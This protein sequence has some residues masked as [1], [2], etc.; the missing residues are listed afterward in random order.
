MQQKSL[1]QAN[2]KNRQIYQ[3][4]KNVSKPLKIQQS[5]AIN[6]KETKKRPKITQ[7]V[8]NQDDY[9]KKQPFLCSHAQLSD[10]DHS[11]PQS[12]NLMAHLK[13]IEQDFFTPNYFTEL[14]LYNLCRLRFIT[15]LKNAKLEFNLLEETVFLA[16]HI[17]DR[18]F[19][20]EENWFSKYNKIKYNKDFFDLHKFVKTDG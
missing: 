12:I 10:N 6:T 17:Y 15:R 14:S 9:T 3:I 1:N 2:F 5:T 18:Y 16:I 7:S 4:S 8:V 19:Q 20:L 11:I 13:S